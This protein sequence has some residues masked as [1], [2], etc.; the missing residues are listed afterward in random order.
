MGIEVNDLVSCYES[1]LLFLFYLY[2][3]MD[4]A[5]NVFNTV[6]GTKYNY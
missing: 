3:I 6:L 2:F 4:N 5:E 1:K